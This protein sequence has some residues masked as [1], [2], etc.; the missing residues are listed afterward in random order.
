MSAHYL[1]FITAESHL[2]RLCHL[3][4]WSPRLPRPYPGWQ[5][6]APD[7]HRLRAQF[8]HHLAQ[9]LQ[10]GRAQ[11]SSGDLEHPYHN[12]KVNVALATIMYHVGVFAYFLANPLSQKEHLCGRS[13]VCWVPMWILRFE[14][15]VNRFWQNSQL[16]S[17]ML[18][19]TTLMCC[20]SF[21]RVVNILPQVGQTKIF[22]GTKSPALLM[23]C[24]LNKIRYLIPYRLSNSYIGI[25]EL[26]L[27]CVRKE[28]L[29]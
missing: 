19:C 6:P 7:C 22:V 15:E 24:F 29:Q 23:L 10:P 17:L 18:L 4:W 9:P 20:A 25:A 21:V 27:T 26:T 8:A 1:P 2:R 12:K 5:R 11:R 16:K 28:T 13:P 14:R 3:S